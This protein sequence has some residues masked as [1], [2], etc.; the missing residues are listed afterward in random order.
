MAIEWQQVTDLEKTENTNPQNEENSDFRVTD[1]SNE[2][3]DDESSPESSSNSNKAIWQ[4]IQQ[5]EITEPTSWAT[6]DQHLAWKEHQDKINQEQTEEEMAEGQESTYDPALESAIDEGMKH[7]DQ[8]S[9]IKDKVPSPLTMIAQK[10]S[11]HQN[12]GDAAIR[13]LARSLEITEE[14]ASE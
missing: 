11:R 5:E 3:E 8:E 2:G 9:Y 13:E 14:N 7:I 1:D 6:L 12:T 4:P 10:M